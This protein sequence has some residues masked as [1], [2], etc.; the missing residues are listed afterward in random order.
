MEMA[1]KSHEPRAIIIG[2]SI[3]SL[4]VGAFL[5]RLVGKSISMNVHQSS[6]SAVASAFS[7]LI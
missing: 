5:G 2:G 1:E 3:A 7:L 4:F 6:S